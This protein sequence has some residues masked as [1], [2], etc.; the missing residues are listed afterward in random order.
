VMIRARGCFVVTTGQLLSGGR[1]SRTELSSLRLSPFLQMSRTLR[2]ITTR[3]LAV[4][5]TTWLGMEATSAGGD[6]CENRWLATSL[7]A[8]VRTVPVSYSTYCTRRKRASCFLR[9]RHFD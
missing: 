5:T 6:A 8:L 4:G 2:R 9:K 1:G 3:K 7:L